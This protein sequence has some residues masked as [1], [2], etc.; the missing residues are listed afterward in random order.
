[1]KNLAKKVAVA[2][3]TGALVT[4]SMIIPAFGTINVVVSGNGVDSENTVEIE[5]QQT[6]TV[7]Q[8]NTANISN[9]IEATANSGGNKVDDSTGGDVEIDTGNATTNVDV[10]NTANSNEAVVNCGGCAPDLNVEISEN[11]DGSKNLVDYDFNEKVAGTTLN[12]TNNA[13]VKNDVDAKANSGYNKVDDATGG[14]VTIDTGKATTDVDVTNTLNANVAFVGGGQGGALNLII[15]GNGVDT[16]NT[17]EVE[18]AAWTVLNQSN[19]ASV[20]NDVEVVANSGKNKIDDATG[21]N[22]EI[23]TGD[24]WAGAKVDTVANFNWA[25]VLDCCEFGG[26]IKIASNGEGSKNLADVQLT[27]ALDVAQTNDLSC[28]RMRY[29][30]P[31]ELLLSLIPEYRHHDKDCNDVDAIADTGDNK[32][33]DSTGS[34]DGDP[35][36]DTGAATTDVNVSNGGNSNVF[37]TGDALPTPPPAPWMDGSWNL[38]V[39]LLTGSFESQG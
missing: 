16:N 25:E 3:A 39:W 32:I 1:M 5:Q 23:D 33:D 30:R 21:G 37:S 14:D 6:T 35:L 26:L 24:A 22:M 29:P 31:M 12:Q 20:L 38:F 8:S 17:L 34:V 28:S 9:D 4:Q 10:V 27:S 15:S 7:N 13:Y 19:Y 11:G 36:I 18:L 2:V